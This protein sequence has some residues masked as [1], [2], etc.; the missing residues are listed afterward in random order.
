[1]MTQLL[2]IL[3]ICVM[4]LST[5]VGLVKGLVNLVN[6]GLDNDLAP[7]WSQAII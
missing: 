2:D 6:I 3:Y 4:A 7:I 5:L 1:M